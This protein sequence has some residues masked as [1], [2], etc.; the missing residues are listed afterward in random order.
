MTQQVYTSFLDKY[1]TK[2]NKKILSILMILVRGM[3]GKF[4]DDGLK[5]I[6]M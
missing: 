3:S 1:M 4:K 2:F 5:T 6:Q